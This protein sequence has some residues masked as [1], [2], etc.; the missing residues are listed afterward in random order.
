MPEKIKILHLE[1]VPS[2]VKLIWNVLK[3]AEPEYERLVVE[4]KDQFAIALEQYSP[5]IILSDHTLPSFNSHEALD[6]LHATGLKIPFILITATMSEEFAVDVIKRG[7]DDY[8]LKD[9]LERLPTAI[10]NILEKFRLEKERCFFVDEVIN[11]EKRYRALI[12]NIRD[13]IILINEHSSVLYQSP[14]VERLI[15]FTVSDLKDII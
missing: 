10:H 3:K 2:D 1:D 11:N 6:I 7:A 9:R 4:T 12:E 8:I 14:S 15:G 5:D 13:A